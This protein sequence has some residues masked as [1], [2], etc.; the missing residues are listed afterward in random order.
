MSVNGRF[1]DRG[2]FSVWTGS[3]NWSPPSFSNDEVTFRFTSKTYYQ[4]YTAR[5]N[6]MWDSSRAT[7]R[8]YWQ[9]KTRPCA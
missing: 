1:N 4:A 3:E 2:T 7:H 9:P 8:I 6:K 5:F